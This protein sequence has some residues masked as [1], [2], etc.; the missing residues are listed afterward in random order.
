MLFQ[1]ACIVVCQYIGQ[2]AVALQHTSSASASVACPPKHMAAAVSPTR[3]GV[4][5]MTRTMR[6]SSPAASWCFMRVCINRQP[7][8]MR[9]CVNLEC[10]DGDASGDGDDEVIMGQAGL[11]VLQ[12][13]SHVLWLD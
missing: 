5:G 3:Q 8:M 11:D 12:N 1:H 9:A 7:Y 4:L 6:L 2:Y 10:V 13:G